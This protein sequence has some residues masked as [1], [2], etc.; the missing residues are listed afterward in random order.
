MEIKHVQNKEKGYF[1]AKKMAVKP[2]L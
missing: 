2:D 1:V